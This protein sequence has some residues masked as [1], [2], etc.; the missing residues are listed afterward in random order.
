[1]CFCVYH[2]YVFSWK[3]SIKTENYWDQQQKIIK[4]KLEL[5]ILVGQKRSVGLSGVRKWDLENKIYM[6]DNL[7]L[8]N[9]KTDLTI[10][11]KMDDDFVRTV[12]VRGSHL[13]PS[14]ALVKQLQ[15]GVILDHLVVPAA[16]LDSEL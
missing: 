15:Q 11:L 6:E 16:T 1:M 2:L 10:F 8:F 5:K 14:G 4:N 7:N 9:W 13:G 3:D 12:F